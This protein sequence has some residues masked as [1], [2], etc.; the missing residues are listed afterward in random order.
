MFVVPRMAK[1]R[2]FVRLLRI[3]LRLPRRWK[4]V[5]LYRGRRVVVTADGHREELHTARRVL[6]LL[7]R[8][9]A[10]AALVRRQVEEDAPIEGAA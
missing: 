5:T 7:V 2:L 3:M 4:G 10:I 6:P 8:P 9:G 1:A